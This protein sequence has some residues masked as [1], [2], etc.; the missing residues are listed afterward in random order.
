[1]QSIYFQLFL[2]RLL[3]A[4]ISEVCF[5]RYC[6]M[7]HLMRMNSGSQLICL[8]NALCC[9][10]PLPQVLMTSLEYHNRLP[11]SHCVVRNITSGWKEQVKLFMDNQ[12]VFFATVKVQLGKYVVFH[13]HISYIFPKNLDHTASLILGKI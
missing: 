2:L 6:I 3:F 9:P 7:L 5:N 4:A 10:H 12:V 8:W 13:F 11:G 1:M